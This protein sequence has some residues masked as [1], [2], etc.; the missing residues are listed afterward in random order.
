[1]KRSRPEP[2]SVA[3]AFTTADDSESEEE[4][5]IHPMMK[6]S[7]NLGRKTSF[8]SGPNTFDRCKRFRLMR[9]TK[10]ANLDRAAEVDS[11]GALGGDA[12]G[13]LSRLR[14]EIP[15]LGSVHNE[16]ERKEGEERS[17]SKANMQGTDRSRTDA[18]CKQEVKATAPKDKIICW[19]CRRK[20]GS[21]AEKEKHETFSDL[22][23]QNL[24]KSNK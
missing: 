16:G 23:K 9:S 8:A 20:F 19:I 18:D 17:N 13:D 11:P 10:A 6:T 5:K 15:R 4:S 21:E 1:M 3:E 12:A 24:L 2:T 14:A 22:H 7:R